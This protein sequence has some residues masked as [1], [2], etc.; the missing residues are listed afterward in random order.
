MC[1]RTSAPGVLGDDV[2]S[3][4]LDVQYWLDRAEELRLQ[5]A[6]MT[7]PS[8]RREMLQIAAAYQKLAKHAEERTAGK[9]A[10]A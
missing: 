7:H 9:R 3:K 2:P 4:V 10:R 5:A 6:E 1:V 8:V